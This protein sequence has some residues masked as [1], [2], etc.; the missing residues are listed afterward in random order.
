MG[1]KK[2]RLQAEVYL[3]ETGIARGRCCL[4]MGDRYFVQIQLRGSTIK[5]VQ[6]STDP[7]GPGRDP[8][9][10]VTSDLGSVFRD[11]STSARPVQCRY[12]QLDWEG[13]GGK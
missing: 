12:M 9:E 13:D 2:A 10:K 11:S 5:G 4:G 7:R 6:P 8:G 3:Y 1:L